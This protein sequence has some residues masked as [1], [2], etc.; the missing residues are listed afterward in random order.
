M[1]KSSVG[2]NMMRRFSMLVFVGVLVVGS[3]ALNAQ[4]RRT[5]FPQIAVGG[6]WSSDLYLTNQGFDPIQGITVSFFRDNGQPKVV[7]ASGLGSGSSFNLTLAAG[8]TRVILLTGGDANEPQGYAEFTS[9]TPSEDEPDNTL[10]ATMIVR[11]APGGVVQTQLGVP[12]QFP[13]SHYS[14]AAEYV[15]GVLSTGIAVANSKLGDP[16]GLDIR[17]LVS[18]VGEDGNYQRTEIYPPL[19]E[20]PLGA[21]Q[22][23]AFFIDNIF[24]GLGNFRGTVTISGPDWFGALALRLEGGALGAVAV[25]EGII[26]KP[27]L[28]S[29]SPVNE[30]ANNNTMNTAQAITLPVIVAGGISDAD[31]VDYFRFTAQQGDIVSIFANTSTTPSV[32]VLDTE[33]FLFDSQG[34]FVAWNDQNGVR[35]VVENDSLIRT[36]IPANGTYYI[37]LWDYFGDDGG[38]AFTYR[39]HV[40]FENQ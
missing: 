2:E 23:R 6:D 8:E 33:I 27:F 24:P 28:L 11:F 14:F 26:L 31:D 22:H 18:L 40:R 30:A 17:L 10:R 19:T 12:E 32:S 39:L 38:S 25:N 35:G 36:V 1:T 9:P 16:A 3:A 5:L 21:G 7:Q 20:P 13:F 37:R 29:Q 4:T 15:P 34:G